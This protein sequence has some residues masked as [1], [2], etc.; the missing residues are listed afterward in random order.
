MASLYLLLAIPALYWIK[1]LVS[2][3][4]DVFPELPSP[5]GIPIFGNIFQIGSSMPHLLLYD[6][7]KKYGRMFKMNFWGTPIIVVNGEDEVYEVL[8]KETWS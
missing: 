2:K 4:K 1:T 3:G 8:V 7:A 6:W 5:P